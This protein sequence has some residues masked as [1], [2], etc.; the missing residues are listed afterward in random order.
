MSL[1][2]LLGSI[3]PLKKELHKLRPFEESQLAA[4]RMNTLLGG[5]KMVASMNIV[6]AY[7]ISILQGVSLKRKELQETH[8][9]T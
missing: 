9:P 3:S 8:G 2:G 5:S 1:E 6:T 7:K 4:A